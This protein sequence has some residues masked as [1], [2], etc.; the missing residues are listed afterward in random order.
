MKAISIILI[1]VG[2]IFGFLSLRSFW[3]DHAYEKAST[4]V[5]ASVKS[6][7]IKPM[8]GKA[9]ASI[10]R[11]LYYI[12]DGVA[13]STEQNYSKLYTNNNPLPSEEELK[14]TSLY[15]RYVPKNRRSETVFPDRVLVSS[16]EEYEGYYNRAMF[17]QMFAFIL[18]GL[19]IR[20]WRRKNNPHNNNYQNKTSSL[21]I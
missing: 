16:D 2:I 19:M 6:V 1:V 8:S 7:D 14:S 20:L 9:V 5:K 21:S 17:G 12:R 11:V 4:T 3:S 10:R 18:L 15:V 13:D